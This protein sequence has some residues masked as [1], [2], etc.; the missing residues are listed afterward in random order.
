MAILPLAA[1][2]SAGVSLI[3]SGLNF[4]QAGSQRRKANEAADKAGAAFDKALNLIEPNYLENVALPLEAFEQE[5]LSGLMGTQQIVQAGQEGEERG[6]IATAGR[7]ALS[8][9]QAQARARQGLANTQFALDKAIAAEDAR[10]AGVKS[11]LRQEEARGYQ[12]MAADARQA[13]QQ[14]MASG[15]QGLVSAGAAGLKA[16][17]LFGKGEG[18]V[19]PA[20]VTS[21]DNLNMD[22]FTLNEGFQG[23]FFE[24]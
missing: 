22:D 14:Q 2:A 20:S 13:Q 21:T 24:N 19:D 10:I 15:A 11:G 17:P 12:A 23:T 5:R 4:L 6:A 1:I 7:A 18:A 3:G 9:Q 8:N 16:L